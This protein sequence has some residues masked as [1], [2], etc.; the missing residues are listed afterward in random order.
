MPGV[1]YK[2]QR[3]VHLKALL[4]IRRRLERVIHPGPQVTVNEQ[5]LA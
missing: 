1:L 4:Q 3:Q 5:L 2:L